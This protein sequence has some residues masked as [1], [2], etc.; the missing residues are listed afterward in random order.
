M[1]VLPQTQGLLMFTL[2][3]S[4]SCNLPDPTRRVT[5]AWLSPCGRLLVTADDY[6]RVLLLDTLEFVVLRMW[7][8]YR[9]AQCGWIQVGE[10]DAPGGDGRER[11]GTEVEQEAVTL[12]GRGSARSALC[13]CIFAARRGIVEV[14][15]LESVWQ[16]CQ[17]I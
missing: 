11:G 12:G 8:G 14:S 10:E 6:G 13:L 5:A 4:T 9:N 3:L 16:L 1:G 7:K 2:V 17:W 15:G